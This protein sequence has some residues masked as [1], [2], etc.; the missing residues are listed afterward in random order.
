MPARPKMAVTWG[1]NNVKYEKDI[2]SAYSPKLFL[3][4]ICD[5]FTCI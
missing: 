3:T 2:F 5:I 4:K 1:V